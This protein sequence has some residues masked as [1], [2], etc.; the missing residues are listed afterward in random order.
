MASYDRPS[1]AEGKAIAGASQIASNRFNRFMGNTPS[2]DQL[3]PEIIKELGSRIEMRPSPDGRIMMYYDTKTKQLMSREEFGNFVNRI[4]ETKDMPQRAAE[5]VVGMTGPGTVLKRG[6]E[7]AAEAMPA[8]KQAVTGLAEKIPTFGASTSALSLPQRT[9]FTLF[10]ERPEVYKKVIGAIKSGYPEAELQKIAANNQV[11]ASELNYLKEAAAKDLLPKVAGA[12]VPISKYVSPT[13]L[14]AASSLPGLPAALEATSGQWAAKLPYGAQIANRAA[15]EADKLRQLASRA[16]GAVGEVQTAIGEGLQG[17]KQ[18]VTSEFGSQTPQKA[19]ILANAAYNAARGVSL[20]SRGAPAAAAQSSQDLMGGASYPPEEEPFGMTMAEQGAVAPQMQ[21]AM[22]AAAQQPPAVRKAMAAKSAVK[23]ATS[24]G[25]APS[26]SGSS[27]ASAP[28]QAAPTPM[29][30]PLVPVNMRGQPN[31]NYYAEMMN[32]ADENNA[33]Y[34]DFVN[35]REQARQAAVEAGNRGEKLRFVPIRDVKANRVYFVNANGDDIALDMND[36]QDREQYNYLVEQSGV[37]PLKMSEWMTRSS[38]PLLRHM[39]PGG[40]Y[41]N[42]SPDFGYERKQEPYNPK[43]LDQAAEPAQQ[44]AQTTAS[45]PQPQATPPQAQQPQA[46]ETSK[47]MFDW[48]QF[49]LEN[50]AQQA[51]QGGQEPS[52]FDWAKK[53]PQGQNLKS[54][55]MSVK[56][57]TRR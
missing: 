33:Y 26:A 38:R 17:A 32:S 45:M 20:P 24:T 8:V 36:K 57:R 19:A 53:A 47:P 13:G 29:A 7:V 23:G 3:D 9:A 35:L 21:A 50:P 4:K 1:P 54:M 34:R 10:R 5:M 49:G 22:P 2:T 14:G 40:S 6:A 39:M 12:E 16:R 43:I 41:Q 55:Q 46:K 42:A 30:T 25:T 31:F 15:F 52:M 28:M 11:F 51:A 48:A 18:A 44:P 56:S 37:N 27:P